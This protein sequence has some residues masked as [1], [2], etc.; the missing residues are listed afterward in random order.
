MSGRSVVVFGGSGYI[1]RPLISCLAEHGWAVRVA[2]RRPGWPARSGP[3]EAV[4][5]DLRNEEQVRAAL[6]GAEAVVNLVGIRHERDQSFAAVHVEGAARVARLAAAAGAAHLLHVSALGIAEDGPSAAGRSK[7]R[8]E[9]VVLAAFPAATI[10]RP[11]LVYGSRDNFF[12]R[13]AAITRISPV[14]PAIGGGRT[15]F[16]PMYLDDAVRTFRTLL[17]RPETAGVTVALVGPE[18]FTFRELMERMLRVLGRRRAFV[19]LPFPV[20]GVLA[21]LLEIFSASPL[22]SDE[23]RLLKTD[24]VAD[25]SLTPAALQIEARSLERGLPESLRP[26]W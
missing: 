3:I 15:R 16:Q 23:V 19:S 8:G 6:V 4:A 10:V 14:I 9:R 18:I 11:S 26:L 21:R 22:T 7:A 1:G 17:E 24:K 25:G 2:S 13:F 5:A 12:A 20:A